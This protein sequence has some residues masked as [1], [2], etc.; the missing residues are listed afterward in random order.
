M[1]T[2]VVILVGGVCW[3]SLGSWVLRRFFLVLDSGW[4]FSLFARLFFDLLLVLIAG[5]LL[6][7]CFGFA[8]YCAGCLVC[9]VCCVRS[10]TCWY[11]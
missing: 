2:D 8:D 1:D 5:E 7:C 9:V 4:L 11:C 6:V 10:V 3:Y